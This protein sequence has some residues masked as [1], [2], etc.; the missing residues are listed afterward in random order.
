MI[1]YFLLE[2]VLVLDMVQGA[3]LFGTS[4]LWYLSFAGE[5]CGGQINF[6]NCHKSKYFKFDQLNRNQ[7]TGVGLN[8]HVQLF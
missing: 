5:V 1:V 4:S 2:L 6:Y 3:E 8:I 7:Y